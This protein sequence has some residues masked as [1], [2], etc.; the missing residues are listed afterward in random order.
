MSKTIADVARECNVGVGTVSRVLNNNGYVS[1]KTRKQVESVLANYQPNSAAREM[2]TRKS[3]TISIVVNHDFGYFFGNP[4]YSSVLVGISKVA[5][6]RGYCLQL[7]LNNDANNIVN[8]YKGKKIDGIILMGTK[9]GSDILEN[10]LEENVPVVS[11]GNILTH[12]QKLTTVDLDDIQMAGEVMYYLFEL[13]HKE[14]GIIV[15]NLSYASSYNR[16]NAY[17]LAHIKKNIPIKEDYIQVCEK[18][19]KANIKEATEKLLQNPNITA[20][21]TFNDIIAAEAYS[22]IKANGKKIPDDISIISFDDSDLAKYIT[23]PLTSVRQPSEEKGVEAIK[24]LIET[25]EAKQSKK[26]VTNKVILMQ[27]EIIVRES[28]KRMG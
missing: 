7:E 8:K 1:E 2:K 15:G 24:A 5:Q 25:I 27:G 17:K 13:G 19:E 11:I 23:P 21:F 9:V 12:E 22:I 16:L 10:I 20:I 3:N 4:I 26:V 6:Q 18:I 14:I 28:C